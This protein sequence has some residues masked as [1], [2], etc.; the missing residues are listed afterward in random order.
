[1]TESLHDRPDEFSNK[2]QPE[3]ANMA[4][5]KS[6]A[7]AAPA[8]LEIAPIHTGEVRLHILGIEP[9][10]QCGRGRTHDHP[11][12]S[13]FPRM[14]GQEFDAF[15]AD[16]AAHG[17]REPTAADDQPIAVVTS[18]FDGASDDLPSG[19][20]DKVVFSADDGFEVLAAIRDII[21]PD[22]NGK[23]YLS[24]LEIRPLDRRDSRGVFFN[25]LPMPA[26]GQKH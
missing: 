7:S 17:L 21:R 22:G 19:P 4:T 13:L 3:E 6:D 25:L 1:V 26:K 11:L 2:Q 8:P 20:P 10:T 24:R 23:P 5:R 15:V 12:A 16:I 9:L 18:L 14:E